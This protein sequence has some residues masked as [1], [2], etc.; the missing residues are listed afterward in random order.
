MAKKFPKI[1][2]IQ[3][4]GSFDDYWRYYPP[5]GVTSIASYAIKYN[6][7]P[8]KNFLILDS[9][10][11]YFLNIIKS[12]KPDIIGFSSFSNNYS[13]ASSLAKKIKK[14]FPKSLIILGG[15]HISLFPK[16]LDDVFHIAVM[17]EGEETFS[18]IIK[19]WSKY[20]VNQSIDCFHFINGI[21]YKD[22]GQIIVNPER[23]LIQNLDNIPPI[24]W[25]LVPKIFF[26]KELVKDNINQKWRD[27]KVYPLFTSRGCPYHCV[28]CARSS[29]WKRVRFFSEKRVV[30]EIET[31]YKT[32]GVTAIQIWDDLFVFSTERLL[33]IQKL[34]KKK[35]LLGKIVFYRVFARTDHF[36][37]E[38][39]EILK[40]LNV[41]SVAFGL[42]SGSQKIL[43]YLKKNTSTVLNNYE[44][45]DICEENKIGFVACMMLGSPSETKM[46]MEKT[47][48]FTKYIFDKKTLEIIDLARSTPF[49]GTELYE[50]AQQKKLLP[51][52]YDADSKFLSLNNY[53][54][55]IPILIKGLKNKK[56]Y[57]FYWKRIK[58]Y[59][60]DL[61]HRNKK[62]KGYWISTL[63]LNIFNFLNNIL[64][65]PSYIQ[66][67]IRE[68]Q[69]KQAICLI[70]NIL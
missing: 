59:E 47:Y 43:S 36:N 7:I 21:A 24:D 68:N 53:E 41:V 56:A 8:K 4:S 22:N 28:F 2:L 38:M 62:Q 25:T 20:N 52:N 50:Y 70:K 13:I 31:L 58:N 11:P 16:T 49:P 60:F 5:I 1:V 39:A 18:Q 15:V 40:S 64:F 32:F 55:D 65:L 42:E 26:R 3:V 9:N 29:L 37:Q 19:F 17:K 54:N 51:E 30:E 44:A 45:V 27:H 61:F 6:K 14:I 57:K 66:K 12:F 67:L 46:D 34:L 35:G 48:Q 10:L 23:D 69:I 63:K 33:K